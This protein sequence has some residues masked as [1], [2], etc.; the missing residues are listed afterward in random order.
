MASSEF[1]PEAVAQCDALLN[2]VQTSYVTCVCRNDD[3]IKMPTKSTPPLMVIH[4]TCLDLFA[5][6]FLAPFPTSFLA[7]D[8]R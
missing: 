3:Q 7:D 1:E 4:R 2:V 6:S 5:I 8:Q